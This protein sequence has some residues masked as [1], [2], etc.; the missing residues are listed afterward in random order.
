MN[1]PD[2]DGWVKH[3]GGPCPIPDAKAGEYELLF[4]DGNHVVPV[5]EAAS[6]GYG[7]EHDWWMHRARSPQNYIVAYRLFKPT[8][9]DTEL[10]RQAGE[11]LHLQTG[12]IERVLVPSFSARKPIP[13]NLAEALKASRA[14]LAAIDAR[15]P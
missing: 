12:W 9:S 7:D 13:E 8:P 14:A 6:W 1:T 15:K 11:A 10:L 4:Q 5:G 2:K 3:D